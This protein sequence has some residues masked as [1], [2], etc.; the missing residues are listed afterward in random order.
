M[1]KTRRN[2]VLG[3]C[4]TLALSA[5]GPEPAL[6]ISAQGVAGMNPGP[7]GADR[8]LVIQVVQMSSA[9]AFDAADFFSL[10]DPATALGGDFISAEQIVL[11]PG[12]AQSVTVPIA[13][14]ATLVGFV[15]GFRSPEGKIFRLKTAAP[16]GAAGVILSVQPGG[17]SLQ[18]V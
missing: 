14:G 15:A 6:T 11:S 4:A 10:Q 1:L 5:C 16:A 13:A 8:P 2:V 9:G 17:L 3:A 12:A 18:S 7:D